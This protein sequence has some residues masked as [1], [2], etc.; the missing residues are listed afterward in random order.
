MAKDLRMCSRRSLLRATIAA[1]GSLALAGC[2]DFAPERGSQ[3]QGSSDPRRGII[4]VGSLPPACIDPAGVADD[5]GSQVVFQLFDPLMRYDYEYNVLTCLAAES[6]TVSEDQREFTFKLREA[7]FHNGDPV[8]AL[9][10]KRAWERI[11]SPASGAVAVNGPSGWAYLLSL[12]EGYQALRDGA[13]T[14]LAGVSCPDERTLVVRLSAAYADFPYVVCHHCLGPVPAAADSDAAAFARKPIGNGP[15]AM[16]GEWEQGAERIELARFA[17]YTG[18]VTTID[19]VRFD[20]QESVEDSYRALESGDLT[21]SACPIESVDANAAS[22]KSSDEERLEITET[23][24]TVLGVSP[25]VSYL[26]CNTA[27]APLDDVRFR[28]ALSMAIDRDGIAKRVYRGARMAADGILAPVVPG[29]REDAWLYAAHD[30]D[31]AAALLDELYPAGPDGMRDVSLTIAYSE[32]S[33]HKNAME[34]IA[35]DL[36]AVGIACELEEVP[37][38][39]L[40]VRYRSGSFQLGR[41]DWTCDFPSADNVLFP[42]FHSASVGAFNFARYANERVDTLIDDARATGSAGERTRMLQEA[43]DIVS[44]ECPVVPY[45][46]GA[47]AYVGNRRIESL[48]IDPQGFAHLGR[49]KLAEQQ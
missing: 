39:D 41:F 6:Y 18:T 19:T 36:A 15:F 31:A 1:A 46:F 38:A 29:Y 28:R 35:E 17:D 40:V 37:F 43:D 20:M 4:T 25:T 12:V 10:F 49:A 14:R 9:D 5:A 26:V 7:T 32:D 22:W 8:R 44:D 47:Y 21:L 27:V 16:T 23:R 34:Q 33:G 2:T 3:V 13:T 24:R 48:H 45:L 30:E 11:I 42:L